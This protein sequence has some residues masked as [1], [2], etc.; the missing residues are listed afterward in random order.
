M[1]IF[2]LGKIY[3]FADSSEPNPDYHE[4]KNDTI[5]PAEGLKEEVVGEHGSQT[6]LIFVKD[7]HST[8]RGAASI[9]LKLWVLDML[10]KRPPP[11]PSDVE[12][13][14]LADFSFHPACRLQWDRGGEY[15][16]CFASLQP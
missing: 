1:R 3:H 10:S 4:P 16:I 5:F 8:T 7:V 15:F 12:I 13:C 9:Q 11:M 14:A 2:E 6:S